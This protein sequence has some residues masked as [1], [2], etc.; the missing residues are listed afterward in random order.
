MKRKAFPN[1][2][3]IIIVSL[4]AVLAIAVPLGGGCFPREAAPPPEAPPPEAPPPE[5]APPEPA[6]EALPTYT[7]RFQGYHEPIELKE[8][9][10]RTWEKIEVMSEGRIKIEPFACDELV[11][12]DD[13][14]EALGLGTIDVGLW[15]SS[16]NPIAETAP[17]ECSPA[18]MWVNADEF[19]VLY[20]ERGLREL[21]NEA[22]APFNAYWITNWIDDPMLLATIE[23]VATYA[24]FEGLRVSTMPDYVPALTDAG[25]VVVSLPIEEYYLAGETGVIDAVNWAAAIY[26]YKVGLHELFQHLTLPPMTTPWQGCI[27][28]RKDLWDDMP[29]WA[30]EILYCAFRESSVDSWSRQY[31]A[32]TYYTEKYF[33]PHTLPDEDVAKLVASSRAMWPEFAER[34]PIAQ[35]VYQIMMDY[36][37]ETEA[38]GL[39]R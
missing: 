27:L 29:P 9:W 21:F 22:Y 6:A 35:R 31:S 20:W 39:F 36:F 23:P 2:K 1:P 15:G 3:L 12:H 19:E 34:G 28:I 10:D 11:S 13:L 33:T 16:L 24:D 30:Q 8:Y 25:A 32:H 4:V 17:F 7:L 14:L 26:Y 5:V 38:A 37:A 18:F